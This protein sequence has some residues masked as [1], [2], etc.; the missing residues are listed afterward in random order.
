MSVQFASKPKFLHNQPT[1]NVVHQQDFSRNQ[2][3]LC[4]LNFSNLLLPLAGTSLRVSNDGCKILTFPLPGCSY[5][6]ANLLTLKARVQSLRIDM[7]S[8]K[9]CVQY[10][11]GQQSLV[12]KACICTPTFRDSSKEI[13]DIMQPLFGFQSNLHTR[14]LIASTTPD[15]LLQKLWVQYYP[16]HQC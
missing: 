8:L 5:T 3:Q 16:L 1:L 7:I 13:K 12:L 11:Q 4:I 15:D 9:M 6:F 10:D 14:I 2:Y